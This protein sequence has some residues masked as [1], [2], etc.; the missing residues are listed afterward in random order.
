GDR[1]CKD[2]GWPGL[3]LRDEHGRVWP[4][5]PHKKPRAGDGMEPAPDLVT[6]WTLHRVSKPSGEGARNLSDECGWVGPAKSDQQPSLRRLSKL[7]TGWQAD[8][9]RQQSRRQL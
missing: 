6:G 9:I 5:P 7:V 1:V 2:Q 3:G 4:D 8:R